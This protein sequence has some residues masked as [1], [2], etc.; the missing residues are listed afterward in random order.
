[1]KDKLGIRVEIGDQVIFATGG[2]S[3]VSLN[4]GTIE[5]IDDN[6]ECAKIKNKSGRILTNMRHSSQILYIGYADSLKKDQ[7]ERFF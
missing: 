2:K 5:S 6:R 7:P 1:M 3:D 4:I